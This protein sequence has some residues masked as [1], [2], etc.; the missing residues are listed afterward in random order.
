MTENSFFCNTIISANIK[1]D[2]T[3]NHFAQRYYSQ[4]K[5]KSI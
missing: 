3:I 2:E 5:I 1:A 4:K